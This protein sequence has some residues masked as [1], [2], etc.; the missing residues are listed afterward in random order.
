MS[1]IR[2]VAREAGVSTAT[3]SRA[4]TTPHLIKPQTMQRI[5]DAARLV[6]YRRARTPT[7]TAGGSVGL[8][9]S[10][11]HNAVGFQF[12]GGGHGDTILHNAFYAPVLHGAQ[13][14][15]S[16]L[17]M[18]MLVH[19]TNFEAMAQS[20]PPMVEQR[21]IS[22]LLL[23]G[24]ADPHVLSTF[25]DYVPNIILVDNRDENG[26]VESVVSDGF[27]GTYAATRFL[28]SLGHRDRIA[29][30]RPHATSATIQDR[31]RGYVCAL[32]EAGIVPNPDNV[33]TITAVGEDTLTPLMRPYLQSHARP[34][35]LICGNDHSAHVVM[36]ICRELGI[37]IPAD[38]SLV[39]FDDI[40]YSSHSDPALTTV[41]VDKEDLG[42]L[43]M[44]RLHARIHSGPDYPNSPERHELPVTL[45][46]RE[47][48]G[49]PRQ[50]A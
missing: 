44:R 42:R 46:V 27:G 32:F 2:D 3:V 37:K 5:L 7:R 4:F 31:L 35:A 13:A 39:G 10:D 12:F 40:D 1:S 18:H 38:M 11:A 33:L 6:D 17:G 34:T 49:S 29:F 16:A 24:T 50:P 9:S 14:Q 26:A 45:V 8:A 15:A 21:I 47:S 28:L 19:T 41:R 48:C 23:V 25:A 36:R 30:L 20:I 43:A 22:G